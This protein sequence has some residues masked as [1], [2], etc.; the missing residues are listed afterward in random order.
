MFKLKRK[1][2]AL[3]LAYVLGA[4]GYIYYLY[5]QTQGVLTENINNK[6][7]HAALGA[8]AILGDRYH[9]NLVDKQSKTPEQDW[10]AIQRLSSFNESMGTAFVYS[11]IKRDA[12]AILISSSASEKEIREKNFVRFFDPYPDA[13]QALLDSFERTQPT[14]IDYSDH[15]GDFRAV[16]VPMKSRDGTVYVAGAEIT[17]E[18]YYQQLNHDS[19]YHIVVAILVFLALILL[20]M[21][22]H[23]QELHMNERLLNQAKQAAEE[24]DRS[25]TR[26]LATMSH[27]IRTPMY[28]VIGATE[29]L[30]RSD[31]DPEQSR[32]LK[33]IHASGRTLLSLIDNVLDLAKIEAG[34]LELKPSI[35]ELRALVSSCIDITRQNIQDKPVVL[36][37]QVS[38]DVPSLIKTDSDCLRQILIN[39]LGNAVKFTD[40]GKIS[41]KVTTSGH[42]PQ[43]WLDFSIRDTGIGI[44]EELQHNL[45]QPFSQLARASNQRFAG[46]GLGLSI[47]KNLVEAQRGTLSFTSQ[48][49]VGSTFSFSLPMEIFPVSQIPLEEEAQAG[50]DSSFASQYPL[51]ILLVENHPV[52]QKVAMAMLQELG[53]SPDLASTGQEAINRCMAAIPGIIF[54]DINMPV[55]DGLEAIRRIRELP[56]G[57]TCYVVAFTASAFSSEIERFRAAGADDVLTKPANFQALTR[58][59]QRATN[60]HWQRGASHSAAAPIPGP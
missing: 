11:V 17:L 36:E 28:S 22:G 30:A 12:K 60:A 19:L 47:C 33:T 57:D 50:Y 27:E 34:K 37:A 39:L 45:F 32:L 38:P 48:P 18:D 25:K 56:C 59:L 3:L 35:F 20:R 26:F 41:L 2:W 21:R 52:S 49:G 42:G 24:A 53:Y 40:S 6:L 9:D 16:F 51:D 46:S 29:L 43:A 1:T 15:W 14:W 23:L 13:S 44:P 55:M 8:S 31:L 7:L 10:D 58:V 54:M 4:S 5:V